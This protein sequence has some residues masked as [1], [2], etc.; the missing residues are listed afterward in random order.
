MATIK[1]IGIGSK[2]EYPYT[3]VYCLWQP[4]QKQTI[5]DSA[6]LSALS[7]ADGWAVVS[8]DMLTLDSMA[9]FTAAGGASV[10][11][12]GTY[13][14][15]GSLLTAKD[16]VLSN[17][18]A[19]PI[20]KPLI[21][22]T[23]GDSRSNTGSTT[24]DAHSSLIVY[25]RGPFWV[26]AYLNGAVDLRYNYGIGGDAAANWNSNARAGGKTLSNLLASDA[27]VVYVQYGINDCMAL[28][29]ANTISG[30]LKALCVEIYKAGKLLIFESIQPI[31]TPASNYVAAQSIADSVNS[32]MQAYIKTYFSPDVAIYV[33]T[34]SVLKGSDGLANLTYTSIADGVHTQM[35]GAKLVGKT[36]A[37]YAT[38]LIRSNTTQTFNN[39]AKGTPNFLNWESP[40]VFTKNGN[41]TATGV[42]ITN[43]EDSGGHYT[44]VTW[45]PATLTSGEAEIYIELA[46]NFNT[47]VSPYYA[48]YGNEV[49]QGSARIIIDN[50]SG[51]K[52]NVYHFGV[53][54][55]FFT[56]G[57]F[58]DS[59][60]IPGGTP[61]VD[62]PDLDEPIDVRMTTPSMVNT[63]ASVS[64]VPALDTGFQY[65][66]SVSSARTGELVRCKIY[67]PQ[68][69]ITGYS[70][71]LAVTPGASPW[72]YTNNSPNNQTLY[73]SGGTV[74]SITH[75]GTSTGVL[76]GAFTLAPRDSLVV[77][78]TVAP[79][80][81]MKQF[82]F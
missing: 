27:D 35:I 18:L 69:I 72:T 73:I 26:S 41:G 49:L 32:T 64:A 75:N 38:K 17:R 36:V 52:P 19:N 46:A 11:G 21:M 14:I 74:S 53:R 22:A 4:G 56:A 71:L 3:G 44:Q 63:A 61:T 29:P 76:A 57:I 45:T 6:R 68:L 78:Y 25:V 30:Y 79:T 48:L 12:D 43:G 28:T 8:E 2:E 31:N 15:G 60:L 24:T 33:D 1:Y 82:S 66:V 13:N 70:N 16:G 65:I 54:Q 23:F 58:R 7:V 67:N 50:G 5:T 81:T 59:G 34:A 9:D 77:T 37:A 80:V 55:R 39:M 47:A 20:A 62:T 10:L 51:G 40:S 42:T